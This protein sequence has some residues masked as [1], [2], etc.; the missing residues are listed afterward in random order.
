MQCKG[1]N[2]RRWLSSRFFL[3]HE[4]MWNMRFAL[5]TVFKSRNKSF[6]S[7]HAEK[8][9]NIKLR[10]RNKKASG[11]GNLIRCNNVTSQL[12]VFYV[13]QVIQVSNVC[14]A[15]WISI[16]SALKLI[17]WKTTTHQKTFKAFKTVYRK[18]K[19]SVFQ[20][21]S[22]RSASKRKSLITFSLDRVANCLIMEKH[23][24]VIIQGTI[25]I[26]ANF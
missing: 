19:S 8:W 18:R 6:I 24:Y 2:E 1:W 7:P 17:Q 22:T 25:N 5:F 3:F 16:G 4:T 23:Y 20:Y 21:V 26:L 12:N 13:W 15:D 9:K 11:N 10:C 14:L